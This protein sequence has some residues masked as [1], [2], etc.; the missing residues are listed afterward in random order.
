MTGKEVLEKI[1]E[2]RKELDKFNLSVAE[3][4]LQHDMDSS[5]RGL[6]AAMGKLD[7]VLEQCERLSDFSKYVARMISKERSEED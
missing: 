7:E 4:R 6:Y 3:F 2:A 5:I 1:K